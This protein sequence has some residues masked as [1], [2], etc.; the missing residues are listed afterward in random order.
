V[1]DQI[2]LIH[3]LTVLD[4]CSGPENDY[5][6]SRTGEIWVFKKSAFKTVFYIKI[7]IENNGAEA[8]AISC[9]I[10]NIKMD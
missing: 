3:D 9:H 7:K 1:Q 10:D 5:E 4:Y 2:D 8:R 6:K